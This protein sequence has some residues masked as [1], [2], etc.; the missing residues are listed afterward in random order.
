MDKEIY[1]ELNKIGED[2]GLFLEANNDLLVEHYE[3]RNLQNQISFP[4]FCFA[5]YAN[6]AEEYYLKFHDEKVFILNLWYR[7]FAPLP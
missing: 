4:L 6:D 1:I 2:F 5:A 3:K 7:S